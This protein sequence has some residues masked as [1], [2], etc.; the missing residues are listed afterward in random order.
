[1][2][3]ARVIEDM[4]ASVSLVDDKVILR[5]LDKLDK[6]TAARVLDVARAHRAELVM[7]LAGGASA[8]SGPSDQALARAE[9]DRFFATA[10]DDG[11]GGWAD[12]GYQTG[13]ET[14]KT[15]DV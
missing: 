2:N 7:E 1:M 13:L 9:L 12:P 15:V 11:A 5:G 6:E 10:V 3:A 14:R 4:G 8:S